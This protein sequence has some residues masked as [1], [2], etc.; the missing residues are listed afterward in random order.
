MKTFKQFKEDNQHLPEGVGAIIGGAL[1]LG[2]KA[3]SAYSAYKA[4]ES[5]VKGKPKQAA[6]NALGAVPGGKVFKGVRALVGA[7]NLAKAGST[8]QSLTRYNVTG[9]T[10]NAYAKGVDKTFDVA[11]KGVT[12]KGKK[13]FG[14]KDKKVEPE[15]TYT[16]YNPKISY[17]TGKKRK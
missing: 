17:D 11:T 3:L 7:K 5:L 10:P 13:L 15:K 8:A 16:A 4:G 12:N 1:K 6:F 14:K 2:G 9:M